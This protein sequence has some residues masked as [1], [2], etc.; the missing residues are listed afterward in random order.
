MYTPFEN[1][2]LVSVAIFCSVLHHS[3]C[4]VNLKYK[5]KATE[6]YEM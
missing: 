4:D 3:C 2:S 6:K 1:G 5:M